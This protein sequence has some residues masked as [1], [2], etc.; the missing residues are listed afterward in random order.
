MPAVL[1]W[2]EIDGETPLGALTWGLLEP[3]Q[4]QFGVTGEYLRAVL[5]N[6]G[7]EPTSAHV[8]IV[9]VGDG[10]AAGYLR[11]AQGAGSPGP[12]ESEGVPLDVGTLAPDGEV[13]IWV[14]VVIPP[15]APLNTATSAN[16]IA[17]GT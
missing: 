13:G 5:K 2:F 11:I 1:E 17:T 9:P 8:A 7:T 10:V 4:S 14:D 12:F 3:G 6:T 15:L 16:L